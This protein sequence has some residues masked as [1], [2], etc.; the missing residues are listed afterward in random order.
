MSNWWE[1]ANPGGPMV[2]PPFI[3]P[4]Y[5][6]D[7]NKKGKDPS[8]DGDD[9]NAIKR[10]VSRSGHWPWQA[11]DDAFSNQFSHGKSGNVSENGLAGLQ[12]QNHV[13]ASGWMGEAT[14]NLIRSARIPT[15]LPNAGEPLLDQIA[16][17]LLTK[18][19]ENWLGPTSTVRLAALAKARTYLGYKESPDGTNGNMFGSWYGMNYEPWCAMFVTYCFELGSDGGSP[20]FVKGSR[21]AY[22]PYVVDDARQMRNGLKMTS[23][24]MPGDL[25]CYDWSGGDFDHIGIFAGGDSVSFTAI[26]GNTSSSNNSNGGGVMQRSRSVFQAARV[27]FV[28]VSEP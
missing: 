13:D 5:P 8:S 26:E 22:V 14:Y 19:R 25:V 20:S 11:F 2:G 24:P 27:A 7:A 16:I 15:G 10:A 1:H 28:R 23:S 12:R 18:F 6:T 4:L 9:I 17:N 3:R 21:Y